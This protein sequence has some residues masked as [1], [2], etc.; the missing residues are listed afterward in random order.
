M[1]TVSA[2]LLLEFLEP[3]LN[4]W[5]LQPIWI[6]SLVNSDQFYL[7]TGLRNA[8]EVVVQYVSQA[9]RNFK[10]LSR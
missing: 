1:K 5:R 6:S 4:L 8:Q 2:L 9:L 10:V 7:F 3:L